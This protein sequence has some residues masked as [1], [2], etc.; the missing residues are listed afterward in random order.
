MIYRQEKILEICRDQSVL[1]LGFLQHK[2][3]KEKFNNGTWLHSQICSVSKSCLGLDILSEEVEE[4]RKDLGVDVRVADC[5]K[6]ADVEINGHFDVVICG[7]L[8]EHIDA[9]GALLE[10][11]KRFMRA[12]SVLVITTP[13]VFCESW[14]RSAWEGNEG[15]TFLNEEHVCWYSYMTLKQLLERHFYKEVHYDY[16]YSNGAQYKGKAIDTIKKLRMRISKNYRPLLANP[17]EK[18]LGLFFVAKVGA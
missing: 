3:W 5:T 6:L 2:N 12:T 18:Q 7:E 11:I 14:V 15:V 4:V 1:H 17:K 9:P 13:N 10:S 16:Y 8:I